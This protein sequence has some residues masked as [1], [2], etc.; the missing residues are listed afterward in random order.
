M[1]ESLRELHE[2]RLVEIS[3]DTVHLRHPLLAEAVR[4]RL[5]P[6]ET[7]DVHL[8][9]ARAM[10]ADPG[11]EPAEVAIHC[12][13]AGAP[14]DELTWRI[15]AARAAS[16]RFAASQAADHWLRALDLWPQDS[17]TAGEPPLRRYAVI[18]GAADQLVL[19]GRSAEETPVLEEALRTPGRVRGG[20]AGR[21]VTPPGPRQLHP[22]DRSWGRASSSSTSRSRC[23]GRCRRL[24]VSLRRFDGSRWSSSGTDAATRRSRPSQRLLLRPLSPE[25]SRWFAQSARS[26]PG[27]SPSQEKERRSTRSSPSELSSPA[28]P[29]SSMTC[30]SHCATPTSCS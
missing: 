2:A 21:P 26:E 24:A 8:R 19:A 20:R 14:A 6:G 11:A 27:S 13:H 17:S 9:L 22:M 15:R 18:A 30:Q 25:T 12:Q 1:A 28:V 10:S 5:M 16:E 4:R 7:A 29:T 23:T 3:G